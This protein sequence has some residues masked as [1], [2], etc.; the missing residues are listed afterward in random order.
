[1]KMVDIVVIF[2]NCNTDD[3]SARQTSMAVSRATPTRGT[4][5]PARHFPAHI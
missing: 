5:S 1:M 4:K 3:L 2:P